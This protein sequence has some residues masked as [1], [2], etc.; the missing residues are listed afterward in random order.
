[1]HRRFYLLAL[2]WVTGTEGIALSQTASRDDPGR[3]SQLSD[4][5]MIAAGVCF[6]LALKSD[7]TSPEAL[8]PASPG[9]IYGPRTSGSL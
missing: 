3:V 4:V 6:S 1:M 7:G 9:G 8:F 2:T 5:V